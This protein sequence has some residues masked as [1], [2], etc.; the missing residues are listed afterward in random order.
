MYRTYIHQKKTIQLE[1]KFYFLTCPPNFPRRS[2]GKSVR[3]RF[4]VFQTGFS[5]N[6][7]FNSKFSN[8]LFS[9]M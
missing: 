1:V 9:N 7:E 6:S 4:H 2:L 5:D 3:L 8:K